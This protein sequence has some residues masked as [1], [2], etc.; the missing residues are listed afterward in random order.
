MLCKSISKS[1]QIRERCYYFFLFVDWWYWN[2]KVFYFTL[3]NR[4]HCCGLTY[5]KILPCPWWKSIN[6]YKY[7]GKIILGS[8][9]TRIKWQS[10]V[11]CLVSLKLK[12]GHPIPDLTRDDRLNRMSP[13]LRQYFSNSDW[14]QLIISLLSSVEIW[15]YI[16]VDHVKK[17][18]IYRTTTSFFYKLSVLRF[19]QKQFFQKLYLNVLK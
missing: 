13:F 4:C 10:N 7:S 15:V 3:A 9:L 17:R 11:D 14:L 16:P 12:K 18:T 8:T 19:V 2:W 1:E 6:I 5:T